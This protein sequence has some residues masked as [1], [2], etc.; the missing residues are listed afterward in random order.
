MRLSGAVETGPVSRAAF[1]AALVVL[2]LLAPAVFLGAALTVHRVAPATAAAFLVLAVAARLLGVPF[3]R[4]LIQLEAAAILP[5]VALSGSWQL[6]TI[7]AAAA[8]VVVLL[9][10]RRGR[11][12]DG[13]L[14]EAATVVFAVSGAGLLLAGV[15]TG[16]PSPAFAIRSGAAVLAYAGV[17]LGLDALRHAADGTLSGA[18]VWRGAARQLLALVLL[19]P[20]MALVLLVH[21]VWGLPATVLAFSSVGLVSVALRSLDRVRRRAAEIARQTR[22]LSTLRRV[23]SLMAEPDPDEEIQARFARLLRATY[24]VRATAVVWFPEEAGAAP[25]ARLEGEASTGLP[26]LVEW[27]SARRAWERP[28]VSS[29]RLPEVHSGAERELRLAPRLSHQ[30]LLP[31]QTPSRRSGVVVLESDDVELVEPETVRELSVVADHLA[32]SLQDRDLRRRMQ[33]AN[34][35][36]ASRAATLRRILEVGNE[37]KAHL[38]VDRVLSSTAE[39]VHRSLGWRVV[40]LS[41]LDRTEDV[42]ERRA[43]VG[44]DA[45]WE[46]LASERVERGDVE[47]WF[48]ERFRVSKSY[49]VP[50]RDR[51]LAEP[52]SSDA[53]AARRGGDGLWQPGDLL[54]VP[55]TSSEKLVGVLSVGGP[56]SGRLPDLEEVQALEIFANQAVT[57]FQSARAYETTRLMSVRDSLTA[58]FNHRYFQETLYRELTRH[59]RTAHPVSLAMIDIDDFKKA[60]DRWGHPTGDLILKGLVE[61]LL[62]GVREMDTVARYGGE[63]FAVILPETPAEKARIV[64]DRLRARVA[65]RIFLSPDVSHPISV[66][67]S[68]G[69][70]TY[71]ADASSKRTLIER[72]DQALYQAKRSG[73]NCVVAASALSD[74]KAARS[75]GA[76]AGR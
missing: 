57:A 30:L 22:E 24:P 20:T 67:I 28:A 32:L 42:L 13:D 14:D 70:A 36:L 7:L 43:Q 50:A 49:L 68:V 15:G 76:T 16:S 27:A 74:P 62:K 60:N 48:A 61:E 41:L 34:E 11:L 72:A 69:V 54:L 6:G 1:R 8:A 10:Q 46:D 29:G 63:E 47:R 75:A 18:R 56:E 21:P 17:R 39:A 51:Y 71:P 53:A 73:K 9:V 2:R 3:E 66:T 65:S 5:A 40:L 64:A 44:L 35:R 38:S 12:A 45:A 26:A 52:G 25:V 23:S 59:E 4:Q 19:V 55:L 58:A 31:L 37:L 33:A